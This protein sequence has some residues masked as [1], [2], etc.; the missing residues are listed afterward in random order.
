MEEETKKNIKS[1]KINLQVITYIFLISIIIT[2]LWLLKQLGAS[3]AF[4][5]I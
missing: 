3:G 4:R 1:I 2:V 5:I